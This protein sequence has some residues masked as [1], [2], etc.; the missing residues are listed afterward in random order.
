M[1][2]SL[3]SLVREYMEAQ[4]AEEQPEAEVAADPAVTEV[5]DGRSDAMR[6]ASNAVIV[7]Q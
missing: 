3:P 6:S 5:V 4:A 1:G 2:S 7:G